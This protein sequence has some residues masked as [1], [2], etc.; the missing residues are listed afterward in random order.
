MRLIGLDPGL[1]LT[2]WGVIDVEGNR[3]R[4]VAHGVIKVTTTGSL[5][6]RL[7]ELFGGIVAVVEAQHTEHLPHL[8][9]GGARRV[10]D[11]VE[12]GGCLVADVAEPVAGGLCHHHHHR[13]P[14][15]DNVVQ[16]TR[17]AGAFFEYRLLGF[18]ELGLLGAGPQFGADPQESAD[19]GG[20]GFSGRDAQGGAGVSGID[21]VV[22]DKLFALA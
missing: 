11:R 10:R 12:F 5:A 2:G 22:L 16:V 18:G 3:L 1:R 6:E 14:M 15:R 13:H 7:N 17:D 9:E 21:H 8:V 19:Q 4:H 20:H